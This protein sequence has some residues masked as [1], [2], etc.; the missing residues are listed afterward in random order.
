MFLKNTPLFICCLLFTTFYLLSCD[1][2]PKRKN[3]KNTID[4]IKQIP[5]INDSIQVDITQK[6]KVL[7]SYSDCYNCHKESQRSVRPAFGDIAKR[8]PVKKV[9]IEMLAHK[10]I[11]G[12]SG[13]WGYPVMDPHPKLSLEDAKTMVTYILSLKSDHY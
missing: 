13:S 8:Y 12:G 9:Y 5:G 7:I 2:K 10:V 4:Y 1:S 3:T 6:G 11:A